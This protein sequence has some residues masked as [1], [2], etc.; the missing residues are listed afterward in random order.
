MK[1][2]STVSTIAF[3]ASLLKVCGMKRAAA[4]ALGF[5][6]LAGASSLANAES[7]PPKPPGEGGGPGLGSGPRPDGPQRPPGPRPEGRDRDGW[8]GRDGKDGKD[9][10]GGFRRGGGGDGGDRERMDA[11]RNMTEEE[12]QRVRE[13]FEKAWKNP[14]V[15]EAR[16]R[17]MKANDEFRETLHNALKEADP[18]AVALLEKHKPQGPPGM[19]PMPDVTDSEFAKKAIMR[20]GMELHA[21]S[22]MENLEF[23]T[24]ELAQKL[25]EVPAVKEA[26]ARL[27]G[28]EEKGRMA[29]WQQ[30]LSVYQEAARKELPKR[31]GGPRRDG[32]GPGPGGPPRRDGGPGPGLGPGSDQGPGPGPRPDFGPK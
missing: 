17:Y 31:E 14:T 1:K 15:L 30:L 32:P 25:Q 27:Q 24:R 2:K 19:M 9:G 28:A 23:P 5:V 16:E 11:F 13:A 10:R 3:C 18:E 8:E 6:L 21:L 4:M 12:R 29:A 22:R 26:I 20:L 7:P